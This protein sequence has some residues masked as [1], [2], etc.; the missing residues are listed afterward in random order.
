[1]NIYEQHP[2]CWTCKFLRQ[3]DV[4]N[5]DGKAFVYYVCHKHEE[6]TIE[7]PQIEYCSSHV[8]YKGGKHDTAII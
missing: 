8:E 2:K 7:E 5:E 4:D 3:Y 6:M 1:M